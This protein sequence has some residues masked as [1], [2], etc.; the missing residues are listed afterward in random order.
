MSLPE[1]WG[2]LPFFTKEFPRIAA[3]LAEET[4][5]ILPPEPQRFAALDACAPEEVR[6]VILGQDPYPTPG[7]AHGLAFSVEPEI[8]PLPRSL[9]N[10]YKELQEEFGAVPPNGDLR[11]WARQGVLLLNTALSVPAGNA[12]AHAK[13]GWSTLTAQVLEALSDQPRAFVLWGG[14]AQKFAPYI[15]G[16]DHLILTSAHPSPL[17][18]RRGFFGSRPFSRVNDWLKARGETPINWTTPGAA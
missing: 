17:S 15:R 8:R 1:R 14:H 10:I 4:R 5:E 6:V 2:H 3:A 9:T 13:L 7:H 18:A 11:F 12:G 16:E